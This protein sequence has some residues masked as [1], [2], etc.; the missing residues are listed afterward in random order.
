M[1]FKKALVTAFALAAG[2]AMIPAV[3]ANAASSV[4][5]DKAHF[6]DAA[7][8]TYLKEYFDL[9]ENGYLSSKEIKGINHLSIFKSDKVSSLK[10]I[11]YL[12]SIKIIYVEADKLT[13]Y[14]FSKVT[15]LKQ[16][17]I[18]SDIETLDVSKNSNLE[19]LWIESSKLK[20][21][22]VSKNKKLRDLLLT[23]SS[24]LDSVDLSK[25]TALESFVIYGDHLK[26]L[27]LT[28]NTAIKSLGL[29]TTKEFS[30]LKLGKNTKLTEITVD[31]SSL[32]SIDLSGCSNLE[33]LYIQS[34]EMTSIDLQKNI[35]LKSIDVY[36][37]N[38]DELDVS[39]CKNLEFLSISSDRVTKGIT[40]SC[41]QKFYYGNRGYKSTASSSDTS[42][43]TAKIDKVTSNAGT[44][45]YKMA[46]E[47]KKTGKAVIKEVMESD[48]RQWLL[49][50]NV[51]YSDVTKKSDFWYSP[52]YYL[53]ESGVVKGYD[54]QT[55]FKPANECSRAQMVT[56]LWRLNGCP[57]PKANTTDFTDV[58][59]TDYFFKPVIWAVEQGITTGISSEKFGPEA[60]C[61][62]AQTVTFLWR[63]AGKP[64]P[65]SKNC[66]FKDVYDTDY[67]YKATVW[68][69]EKKIVAGYSD[70]TFKPKDK[71]LRRQMVTFLYKYIKNAAG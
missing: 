5:I 67:Y 54:N 16:L 59:K 11:E 64:D 32:K 38:I 8:R 45:S 56:F 39:N 19:Y 36:S 20:S 40:V 58:A 55:K 18:R 34:Y 4:K 31:D 12:T 2:I 27:D 10:G 41:G 50:V 42:I 52:T 3:T 48:S 66:K 13:N 26:S 22:D 71:C 69:S 70:G 1:I 17:S 29:L 28:K 15:T 60:I 23:G 57:K 43:L 21:I 30:S 9:D 44:V 7:F 47:A 63:M 24:K 65:K 6:P 35:K 62:R 49:P 14:D 53:S 46:V 37:T 25:N 51:L 33:K 68:A 61:T